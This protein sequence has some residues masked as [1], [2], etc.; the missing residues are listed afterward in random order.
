MNDTFNGSVNGIWHEITIPA[1]PNTV[2]MV[3]VRNTSSRR[4]G[5]VREVGSDLDRKTLITA[6]SSFTLPVKVSSESKIEVY[7]QNNKVKFHVTAQLS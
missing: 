4:Y 5:G 3:S 2:V 1:A 6:N 7:R